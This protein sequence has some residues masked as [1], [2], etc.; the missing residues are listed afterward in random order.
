L[1]KKRPT[2]AF[3]IDVK[4]AGK[5]GGSTTK[6]RYGDDFYKAINQK[7]TAKLRKNKDLLKLYESFFL[8]NQDLYAEFTKYV[9][10]KYPD[11]KYAIE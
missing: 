2:G 8:D 1:R 6:E 5:K 3:N 11:K 4:D 9:N 7:A 10:E